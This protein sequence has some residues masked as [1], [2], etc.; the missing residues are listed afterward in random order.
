ML[1]VGQ[2]IIDVVP[3]AVKDWAI[4]WFGTADKAVLILGTVFSLAVIGSIVGI[5]AVQG[6]RAAA[7][8]V[9]SIVG[10]IGVWAVTMRPDPTFGKLLPPIVGTL[11][12]IAVV[13]WLSPRRAP[14]TH[15]LATRCRRDR[16]ADR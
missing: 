12:S 2:E 6:N 5:L 1:P 3:P 11:A 7:Y 9:T 8:A 4:D 14:V 15:G 10:V 13:W 16:A